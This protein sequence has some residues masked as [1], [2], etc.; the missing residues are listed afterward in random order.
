VTAGPE[1]VVAAPDGTSIAVFSSGRSP[2]EAP[3]ILL[4]HGASADHTTWRA[5]G[6]LLAKRYAVAAMDR[7]G[8]GMSGDAPDY[9]IGREYEDVAAVADAL[10]TE[11]GRPVAVV[12]HSY[13]GRVALGAALQT[14]SIGRVVCYEGA[15]GRPD[16]PLESS[17]VMARLEALLASGRLEELLVTFLR[18]VLGMSASDLEAY[19]AN[20]VWPARVAAARTIPRELAAGSSTAAGTDALA[21]V[22]VPVLQILGGASRPAFELAARAL[23]ERLPDGRVLVLEGA[24]HGAHHTHVE[25]FVAAVGAFVD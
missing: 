20:P 7:R 15:P 13:G 12:G 25:A 17:D 5:S 22:P 24:A 14:S 21:A 16:R 1:L 11:S 10:A 8:R 19:R 9:A 4:V 18:D 23:D 6:P 2:G 3:P